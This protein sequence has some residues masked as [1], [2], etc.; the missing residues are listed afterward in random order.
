LLTPSPYH[1][2]GSWAATAAQDKIAALYASICPNRPLPGQQ[3]ISPETSTAG[4]VVITRPISH[5]AVYRYPT[6]RCGSFS[7]IRHCHITAR[8][9]WLRGHSL[10]YMY[11]YSMDILPIMVKYQE[12]R[13]TCEPRLHPFSHSL[14]VCPLD[15]FSLSELAKWPAMQMSHSCRFTRDAVSGRTHVTRVIDR[16]SRLQPG[17]RCGQAAG[18]Q[19]L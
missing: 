1:K 3:H 15:P 18:Q 13:I 11:M 9:A 10:I 5:K 16:I 17:K 7:N 12:S 19:A 8:T 14:S 2:Q 4:S 6:L